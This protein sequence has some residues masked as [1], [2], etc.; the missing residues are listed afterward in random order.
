MLTGPKPVVLVE[1]LA[2]PGF[3]R[4][5]ELLR[6][7]VVPVPMDE[8]GII[9]E[10]LE[11]LAQLHEAQ[12][13]CTSCE[14]H[15]PTAIFTPEQRRHEIAAVAE[16]YD[17]QIIEDDCY[18]MGP[19][20]APSYRMIAPQHGWYISS[21][22]KT[23]TPALRIGFAIAPDGKGAGLRMAAENG[24]FGLAAPLGDLATLLLRDPRTVRMAEKVRADV[25]RHVKSMVNHLGAHDLTWLEDV[26][27]A[28]LRLP[29]GWRAAAFCQA[30][31]DEG[32][33]LRPAEDF[34]CRNARAPHAVRIAINA[35]L[36]FERFE[37]AMAT[38]RNLLDNPPERI[39]V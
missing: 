14:V 16:R 25:A 8:N 9:P 23:L 10:A 18:R 37:N 13:L 31:A 32:I 3:R 28:W 1:E 26:P 6:A 12:A 24:F 19:F 5:A 4:A 38:L 2:Y 20:R 35:Q 33:K 30:A 27:I 36:P 39:G 15:N 7:E 21:I 34:A 29:Q 22:S 17:F 11:E